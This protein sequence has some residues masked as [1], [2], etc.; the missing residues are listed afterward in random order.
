MEDEIFGVMENYKKALE[1]AMQKLDALNDQNSAL[2]KRLAELENELYEQL[3]IPA[4]NA[5][6][7][8]E[9][10]D[11]LNSF[12]EQFGE[13]I[14]PVQN[15][16]L[17]SGIEEEGFDLAKQT[18]DDYNAM[19][20]EG[21]PTAEEYV[22]GVV[23]SVTAQIDAIKEKLNAENLEIKSDEKGNVEVKADGEEVPPEVIEG[24]GMSDPEELAKFEEDLAKSL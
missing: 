20:E 1:I 7:K 21:K 16:L 5:F 9:Y 14:N 22:T 17:S 8:A 24:G 23:D 12:K 13:Q 10:D 6:D 4:K 18:Y 2:E 15:R 3:L 19:P 11:G